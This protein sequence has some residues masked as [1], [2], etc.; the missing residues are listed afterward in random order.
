MSTP[1]KINTHIDLLTK[2]A[3]Q[4]RS[5]VKFINVEKNAFFSTLRK[6][7]DDYFIQNHF[8]KYGNN[9]LII[10]TV[11]MVS[12]YLIPFLVI[13]FAKPG[14]V[15]SLFLWS[16]MGL[17]VAGLGMSV[18]H[19]A[20]HGAYSINKRINWLMAHVL[21]MIGGSTFNWKL[22]HNVLHHTYTNITNMDDDIATKPALRL[23]PHAPVN[24]LHRY[25]WI[26]SFFLYGLTTLYW[27]TAKDF[28]QWFR[29]QKNGVNTASVTQNRWLLLKLV[30]LKLV[31]FTI[32]LIVPV[33]VFHIPILAVVIGFIVMHFL[34]GLILT[35]I[36]QLAHSLE[37]TSHPMPNSKG[38]IENDWAIHQ[39]NTTTNFAVKN[40]WL[41]WYVGGLN[42]Q[43]EHH[44][45]PKISHVHYPAIAP[46]VRSTAAEFHI[47][48][49]EYNTFSDALRAHVLFL[50]RLGRTPNLDEAIG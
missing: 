5:A 23:S 40:K 14:L 47:P 28:I 48:Y 9:K 24:Y 32:F 3:S 41:S 4:I 7:V 12:A 22:Q 10:K 20:N 26:H 38:I 30:T 42:F 33:L 46:I 18:M 36:F 29:Y 43:V 19:D 44:L 39:M 11:I 15:F 27:V 2:Q 34:A 17:S 50:K 16:L 13:L 6:R 8:S 25:Q 21:N 35:V 45:F 1:K 31:Y 37:G 49:L